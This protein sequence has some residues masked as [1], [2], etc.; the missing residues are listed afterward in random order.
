MIPLA[1]DKHSPLRL[2]IGHQWLFR[3]KPALPYQVH[4]LRSKVGASLSSVEESI[5]VKGRLDEI[6]QLSQKES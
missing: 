4:A 3:L 5:D 6:V 1:Y 2:R